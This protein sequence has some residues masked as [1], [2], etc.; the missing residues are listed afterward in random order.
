MLIS[1]SL[2]ELFSVQKLAKYKKKSIQKVWKLLFF[3]TLLFPLDP[4]TKYT[5]E[6]SGVCS[7]V[8]SPDSEF[9]L[10]CGQESPVKYRAF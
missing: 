9:H 7:S 1:S 6:I 3:P 8:S 5:P 10:K 4:E 2:S